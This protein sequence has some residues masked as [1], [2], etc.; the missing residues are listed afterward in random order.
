MSTFTTRSDAALADRTLKIAI[1]RTA[2]TAQ[3]KRSAAVAA[4]PDF[5]AARTRAAA[6]K[7]HV[8]ANLAAYLQRFEASAIAAGTQVHW[9]RTADE[10]CA[11]VVGICKAAGAKTVARS[12]SM[13][14]EEIGL[15]HALAEAGIVRIETDLA[16][17]IIQLADERPSHI[18]WPAMHK[19]REQVSALF[20][21]HHREPHEGEEIAA[22]AQSARRHLR[23]AMLAADVGISG[24][25][26]LVADTGAVVTVT[27]EGNAELSLVPPRVHIVTA[28]I[29][30]V[31]P[32][33]DHAIHLLR[34]LARSATGA[35]LTQYTSFFAGPRRAGDADGPAAMHVVLID[36]GRSAMRRDGL[37]DMLRCIRCGACMNHCVVFRQIGGHAYGGTYPGPLGAVLTPALDGLKGNTDLVDACTLN[38]KCQEV[39]PV[40]I[41][42]PTLL[43]GWREK[44]WREGLEPTGV[45]GGIAAWNQLI[46]H[47]RLYRL[48]TRTAARMLKAM[49]RGGW[50]RRLPLAGG[51]TRHRDMPQPS[52]GTFLDQW[53]RR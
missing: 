29:E 15:P 42:L 45:R 49:G 2:G 6:I 20:R 43:R 8:T 34:L 35:A 32:S 12:K 16:E 24:A 39:C 41:P 53:H 7:D 25:N 3:V 5:D 50:V 17:H 40:R 37:A 1:D 14:G 52:G 19:T 31:V 47:P 48:A 36:N 11:I 38:G 4:W 21:R 27:N 28:G 9:A 23:E 30:K 44:S 18:V 33:T 10:A 13:L 22:M 51:W 46:A 26:F